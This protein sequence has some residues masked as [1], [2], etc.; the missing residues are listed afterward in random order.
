MKWDFVHDGRRAFD[1]CFRSFCLPGELIEGAP[2]AMMVDNVAHD[3]AAGILLALLDPGIRLAVAG[4]ATTQ[5]LAAKLCSLTGAELTSIPHAAFV[6]ITEGVDVSVADQAFRGTALQPESGATL[7][8]AGSW[9]K[10]PVTL[11]LPGH[12]IDRSLA[13]PMPPDEFDAVMRANVETPL[14]VDVL[15]VAGTSLLGLPRGVHVLPA[16]QVA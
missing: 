15:V 9:P 16:S 3:V 6:L 1:C 12:A 13:L 7:I 8:Y 4:P 10:V 2:R 5:E 11:Q 14:G